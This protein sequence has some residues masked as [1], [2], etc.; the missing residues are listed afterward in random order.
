MDPLG[1]KANSNRDDAI[2]IVQALREHGYVAYFAG[3]CVR[4][5]LLGTEPKDFDVATNAEPTKV[6]ELFKK[7]QAVG[8]AFGVILVRINSSVIE[9]ATFRAEGIYEDGRRPSEV[10]FTT[11]EEDA[12]RRDFTINGL[13]FDPVEDRIIDHVGG[14]QDLNAKVLRAIGA[15]NERFAEDHL[16]MLR[17][18]RFAAR[19]GFTIDPATSA[20]IKHDA[21]LL[22]KIS[23]ERIADELCRMLTPTTRLSALKLLWEHQLLEPSLQMNLVSTATFNEA[24][25]LLGA[26]PKERPVSVALAVLCTVIDYRWQSAGMKHDLLGNLTQSEAIKLEKHIR[27]QLKLSNDEL[28]SILCICSNAH[29]LL[30]NRTPTLALLKRSLAKPCAVD[31]RLLLSA[32]RTIGL[33]PDRI[34][35]LSSLLDEAAKTDCSPPALL[36][37]D[38]LVAAGYHPGPQFKKV[39]DLVYDAQLEGTISTYEA[40]LELARTHLT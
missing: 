39:L 14:Q 36:T 29:G 12:K 5:M 30:S 2:L 19:L 37:G 33:I 24:K 25:S 23:A 31:T 27:R 17:A 7:T 1:K 40:A 4:D 26:L 22:K 3:G 8:Q 20:A 32:I 11:A 15:P 38:H 28:E 35:M 10:R 21:P 6:R 16:R 34:D 13:F 18:I 9:V